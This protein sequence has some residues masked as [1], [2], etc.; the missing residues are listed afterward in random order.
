MNNELSVIEV[1][2]RRTLLYSLYQ[3]S[4]NG[5]KIDV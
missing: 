5:K 1:S 4:K 3:K 2:E